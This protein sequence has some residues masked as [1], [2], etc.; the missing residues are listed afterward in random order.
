MVSSVI[1]APENGVGMVGV[2]PQAVIRSWDTALG[3][4]TR[5]D[6]VEITN[7]ILAAA[8]AGRGS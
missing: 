2:Y 6:S 3:E 5:L 1:G 4:G 7:G 8:R